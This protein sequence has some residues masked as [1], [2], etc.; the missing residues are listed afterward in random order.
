MV[1]TLGGGDEIPANPGRKPVRGH[2]RFEIGVE[3][4]LAVGL[5]F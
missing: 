4:H 2:A 1:E 3:S 5:L